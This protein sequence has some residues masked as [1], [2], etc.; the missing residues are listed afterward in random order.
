MTLSFNRVI[1]SNKTEV[2]HITPFWFTK[3]L[4]Q[5]ATNSTLTNSLT[6]VVSYQHT[7]GK[8]NAAVVDANWRIL[9]VR[10]RLTI[11]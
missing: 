9:P 11:V 3:M 1:A 8:Q 6:D 2:R 10:N 5:S 7:I 4:K